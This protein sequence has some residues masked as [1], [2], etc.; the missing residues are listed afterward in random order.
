VG[1]AT[2][3]FAE[4]TIV[5]EGLQA[6]P[7]DYSNVRSPFYS[8]ARRDFDAPQDWTV[9]GA[10]ALVLYVRG[11]MGNPPAPLYVTLTDSSKKVATVVHPDQNIVAATKWTQW[12]IPL[13]D[14]TGVNAAKVK[15]LC[16]GVGDRQATAAGGHGLIF[17]DDICVTLP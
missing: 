9:S 5:H 11:Q 13:S 1:N 6:M 4:Q 3:P 8:E 2:A 12:K 14:F 7:F 16:V 15:S 17:V 10:G